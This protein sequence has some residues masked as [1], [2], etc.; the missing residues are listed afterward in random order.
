MKKRILSLAAVLVFS[1]VSVFGSSNVFADSGYTQRVAL[2]SY[3]PAVQTLVYDDDF[4]DVLVTEASH[5]ID[6]TDPTCRSNTTSEYNVLKVSTSDGYKTATD[7]AVSMDT[8]GRVYLPKTIKSNKLVV[9]F[10]IY[11]TAVKGLGYKLVNKGITTGS[12]FVFNAYTS[13]SGAELTFAGAKFKYFGKAAAEGFLNRWVNNTLVYERVLN[14]A[15]T[16]YDV[17]LR[18]CYLDGTKYDTPSAPATN[19]DWWTD[20]PNT[21]N[22]YIEAINGSRYLDNVLV[23]EP[24][25]NEEEAPTAQVAVPSYLPKVGTLVLD[26][27]FENSTVSGS[28]VT[29]TYQYGFNSFSHDTSDSKAYGLMTSENNK[30][31]VFAKSAKPASKITGPVDSDKFVVSFDVKASAKGGFNIYF[32]GNT[33]KLA[34]RLWFDI[35]DDAH[36]KLHLYD[37][38]NSWND[39]FTENPYPVPKDAFVK[40]SVVCQRVNVDGV[41]KAILS[42]AYV[43]GEKLSLVSNTNT[44]YLETNWFSTASGGS[45]VAIG[46][47]T[48]AGYALDNVIAYAPLEFKANKAELS[49]DG[50]SATVTFNDNIGDTSNASVTATDVLGNT[51]SSSQLSAVDNTLTATFNPPVKVNDKVYTLTVSGVKNTLGETAPNY[52]QVYGTGIAG[53]DYS[54]GEVYIKNDLDVVMDGDLIVAAY[55]GSNRL[56]GITTTP[57]NVP[58]DIIGTVSGVT[59]PETSET[60]AKYK[61][62]VW[63]GLYDMT[64]YCYSVEVPMPVQ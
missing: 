61:V 35:Y 62:F 16:G 60:P 14:S 41:D 8:W 1:A 50:S 57:V 11:A 23:Y 49:S 47:F 18:E 22:F 58:V 44:K 64:P 31:G 32:G 38:N 34:L 2:K 4:N 51:I 25:V 15:G 28:N 53:F 56:M 30:Y 6:S 43:N 26:D 27:T 9:S 54:K 33:S 55:D 13:G 46:N 7:D 21:N 10:D 20:D 42:E 3:Q 5:T 59:L 36:W 40:V 48:V 29:N 37:I 24:A 17:Y 39:R 19:I 52:T 12:A 63:K 45:P